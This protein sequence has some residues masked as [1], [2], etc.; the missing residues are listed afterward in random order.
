MTVT[1]LFD[2]PDVDREYAAWKAN[3]GPCAL[4]AVLRRSVAGVRDLFPR[5]PKQPWTNPTHMRAALTSAGVG[6]RVVKAAPVYGL[7]FVQLAGPWTEPGAN[8]LAAYRHTH[9][10]GYAKRADVRPMIY[11]VNA[12]GWLWRDQWEEEIMSA[13]LAH[14]KRATGFWARTAIEL[15]GDAA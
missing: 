15:T 3:C 6:H 8:V 12:R 9:W 10:V 4:A 13:I 11:D 1:E 2:P 14:T 7:L 5:Y